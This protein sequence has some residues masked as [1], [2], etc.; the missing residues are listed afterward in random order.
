MPTILKR[1]RTNAADGGGAVPF[2]VS[3]PWRQRGPPSSACPSL[4]AGHTALVFV[5]R[6]A[7]D[8]ERSDPQQTKSKTAHTTTSAHTHALT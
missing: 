1:Y 3:H 5:G 2:R 6:T 8:R 4:P 7:P